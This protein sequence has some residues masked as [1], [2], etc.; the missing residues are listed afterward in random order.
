MEGGP[1]NESSAGST[2]AAEAAAGAAQP[3]KT[4]VEVVTATNLLS[5]FKTTLTL[6]D[7]SASCSGNALFDAL[8]TLTAAGS[9]E[10]ASGALHCTNTKSSAA[11]IV[12]IQS[13]SL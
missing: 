9:D 12:P 7:S 1:G 11:V 10:A 6:E 3:K 4:S 13:C 2:T 5:S 8:D